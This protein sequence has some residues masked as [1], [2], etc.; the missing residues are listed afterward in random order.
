MKSLSLTTKVVNPTT[1]VEEEVPLVAPHAILIG[2]GDEG[3]EEETEEEVIYLLHQVAEREQD[4]FEDG[5]KV[6]ASALLLKIRGMIAKVRCF[7]NPQ[8]ILT[9]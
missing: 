5:D 2:S 3:D 4:P 1:G 9:I 6:V 8:Y 7:F